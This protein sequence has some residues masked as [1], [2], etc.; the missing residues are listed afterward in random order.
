MKLLEENKG[1]LED[2]DMS[3]AAFY[4]RPQNA[5][6]K[7]KKPQLSTWLDLKSTKLQASGFCCEEY[8][9][10]LI[11]SST[12]HLCTWKKRNSK[13]GSHLFTILRWKHFKLLSIRPAGDFVTEPFQV[14][15][16]TFSPIPPGVFNVK[17]CQSGTA[18][19]SDS[20]KVS[21]QLLQP[22]YNELHWGFSK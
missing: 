20:T 10:N 22:V 16:P 4:I 13:S 9:F 2:L 15:Y 18:S 17:R 5:D 19:I 21:T 12:I 6:N 1:T 7:N 3:R 11:N 8:D 14:G